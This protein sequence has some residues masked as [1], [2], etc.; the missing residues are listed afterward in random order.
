VTPLE[1]LEA[2]EARVAE[3]E[4]DLARLTIACDD[5]TDRAVLL[6]T[7]IETLRDE[8]ADC[9]ADVA[10]GNA[11]AKAR[12]NALRDSIAAL[13]ADHDAGVHAQV[14]LEQRRE[15]ARQPLITAQLALRAAALLVATPVCAQLEMEIREAYAA[16]CRLQRRWLEVAQSS[17]VPWDGHCYV[18]HGI[19]GE[20][21][22][23]SLA[24]S[25]GING[26]NLRPFMPLIPATL[27]TLKDLA[28][29]SPSQSSTR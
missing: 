11:K 19:P 14:R 13:L 6:T 8:H 20:T 29:R 2:A 27:A 26:A 9:L 1:N 22:L 10:L 12:A 16:F 18:G 15:T 7:E 17:G 24:R 5:L 4:K 25:L 21:D 3:C 28:A 23:E